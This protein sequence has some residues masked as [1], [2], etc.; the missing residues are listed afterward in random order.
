[1]LAATIHSSAPLCE[2]RFVDKPQ[3]Y[4]NTP[5][6]LNFTLLKADLN[7]EPLIQQLNENQSLWN[8]ITLRQENPAS[9]HKDT[10]SIF[11]RWSE[12]QTLDAALNDLKTIHYPAIQVLT[13]AIPLIEEVYA[14]TGA[15]ELGRVL[16]V[17]FGAGGVIEMHAD[18]GRYVDHFERFHLPLIS[19]RGNYFLSQTAEHSGE[20]V[21]MNP[22][23][24]WH[25]NNKAPHCLFNRSHRRRVHL[26]MDM[27]SKKYRRE[28][29]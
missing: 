3:N 26:V 13:K 16:L 4:L 7:V 21:H 10:R 19:G 24:L 17:E 23:E 18:M 1:M 27:K 29:E 5:P 9:Y 6:M 15:T 14:L 8:D 11:L 2:T 22:G 25:F 28:R 12:H 20:F